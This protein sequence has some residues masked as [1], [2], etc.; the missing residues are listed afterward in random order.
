MEK[1]SS[2]IQKSVLQALKM[3]VPEIVPA[4]M[5]PFL[6]ADEPGYWKFIVGVTGNDGRRVVVK[7]VHEDDDLTSEKDKIERQSM[8]SELLRERGI[9]TPKRYA[10]DGRFCVLIETCA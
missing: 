5:E 7:L 6:I 3:F 8:F 1:L 10:A 9:R 4:E 2:E